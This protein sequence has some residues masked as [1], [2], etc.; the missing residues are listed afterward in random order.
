VAGISLASN[1]R[2]EDIRID[3]TGHYLYARVFATSEI[4]SK[5]T[6]WLYKFDLQSR[7]MTRRASVSPNLLPTPF[8]P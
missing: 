3:K 7:K 5:D 1:E 4:K 8:R 2:T 6:T